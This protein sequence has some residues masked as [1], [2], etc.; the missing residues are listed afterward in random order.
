ML[1]EAICFVGLSA[2]GLFLPG[3]AHAADCKPLRYLGG[4]PVTFDADGNL[5]GRAVL[6]NRP[7]PVAFRASGFNTIKRAAKDELG[8]KEVASAGTIY[9]SAGKIS[10]TYV[11]VSQFALG[12]V[13]GKDVPFQVFDEDSGSM[14][15]AISFNMLSAYDWDMDFGQGRLN[16]FSPDHCGN[17]VYWPAAAVAIV[18]Y[19]GNMKIPVIIEGRGMQAYV[20]PGNAAESIMGLKDAT[21]IFGLTPDSSGMEIY[22]FSSGVT[23]YRHV[24][25]SV[26]FGGVTVTNASFIIVP[27]KL[28]TM[29]SEKPTG[30]LISQS[31]FKDTRI[32]VEIGTNVMRKLHI[33]V[34]TREHKLYIAPT[35]PAAAKL[36]PPPTEAAPQEQR[37]Q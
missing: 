22:R 31:K 25:P 26:S 19:D 18:P 30:S 16:L 21:E 1:R 9:S 2:L 11:N 12:P 4:I 23:G 28:D 15:A 20:S 17:G 36:L 14:A 3:Q 27:E 6:N 24:F 34:S 37:S 5:R 8:L 13:V 32:P 29:F 35:D 33:Y 7:E 10:N